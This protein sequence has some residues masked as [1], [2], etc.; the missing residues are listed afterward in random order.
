LHTLA[1]LSLFSA[2]SYCCC[3]LTI[4]SLVFS[5]C[6]VGP[7][8]LH[9]FPTRRSSDLGVWRKA[10]GRIRGDQHDRARAALPHPRERRVDH[11]HRRSEEHTS[12]LQ[13][14]FDLVCRLLLEKKKKKTFL[15]SRY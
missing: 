8:D 6:Y 11:R 9:S 7:C 5:Y 10:P 13:S 15:V 14:R 12:E 1:F 3:W 4:L 2:W